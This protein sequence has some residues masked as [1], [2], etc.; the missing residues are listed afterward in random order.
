MVGFQRARGY[1]W[2][3]TLA[4]GLDIALLLPTQ[5]RI[6]VFLTNR[7]G[8]QECIPLITDIAEITGNSTTSASDSTFNV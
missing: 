3:S 4:H 5:D 7:S 2:F 8:Y 1:S 6:D